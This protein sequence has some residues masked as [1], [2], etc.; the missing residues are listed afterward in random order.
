MRFKGN[1]A[2]V[3][4]A[5]SFFIIIVSVSISSGFRYEI[6]QGLSYIAGD[7]RITY[8]DMNYVSEDEPLYSDSQAFE[9]F[10]KIKGIESV[11]PVVY[12]AGIIKSKDEIAGAV[13]KGIKGGG[14]SLKI[15]IPS[16]LADMLNI[17]KGD[18]LTAYFIGE[19][20]KVRKFTVDNIY[21]NI[22]PGDDN[23]LIFCGL[24][25]MQRLNGWKDNQVSA[26]EITLS[27][28]CKGQKALKDKTDEI[29]TSILLHSN[30]NESAPVA[31]SLLNRYPQIFSWLDL[32]DT[33]VLF[34]LVLMTIVAGFNM[35]SG[36]LILLFRNIS[37]IGILKS[38]GMTNKNISM[39]FLKVAS[40][41]VVKG[42]LIGNLL[43]IIF[44]MFQKITRII[45]LDPDNYFLSYV[46]VRLEPFSIL[47]CDFL[48]YLVIMFLLLLPLLF[49]SNVDPAKTV[50]SQ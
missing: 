42:M 10:G 38:M 13:F 25:D 14:D 1:M 12:R 50:R 41:L 11:S 32:I 39:V 36:L 33:N 29:G 44:C 17:S 45:K 37:T 19:R 3:S 30:P 35:I 46:P 15:S 4:I 40:V 22:L 2:M 31:S 49:V 24:K 7:V 48:S 8:P 27:K 23:M 21:T 26:M 47:A 5:I 16:R 6:R 34:I 43:A 20:V 28:E 18:K 9:N